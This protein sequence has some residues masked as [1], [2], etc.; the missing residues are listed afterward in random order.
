MSS[1]FR[2]EARLPDVVN[3]SKLQSE[4]DRRSVGMFAR[5]CEV[6]VEGREVAGK[7][8]LYESAEVGEGR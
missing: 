5:R 8:N 1:V 2:D 7:E 6:I 4:D 3:D